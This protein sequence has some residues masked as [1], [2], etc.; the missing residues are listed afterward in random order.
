[1]KKKNFLEFIPVKS[2]PNVSSSEEN[3]KQIIKV[4]NKG[5]YN[6]IA[7]VVFKRPKVTNIELDRIGG[8]VWES[9]DG[10]R[11]V[12]DIATLL[13]SEFG[14]D[15]EPLYDRLVKFMQILKSA[16]FVDF[17]G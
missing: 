10:K 15:A 5:F 11:T 8:F 17:M 13:S 2:N 3:G 6:K 14:D 9:I 16:G 12:Y 4:R 1:M 7:Q